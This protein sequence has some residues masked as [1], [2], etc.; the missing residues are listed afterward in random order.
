MRAASGDL[1]STI[2]VEFGDELEALA[3]NFNYMMAQIKQ[4]QEEL[5]RSEKLAAVG[6]VVNT[7][8]HDC[9][10]LITVIKGFASVL[11]EFDNSPAQQ[12]ECLDFIQFEVDRM[13]RMLDEILQF[14]VDLKTSLVFHEEPLDDFI[15]E[16]YTEIEVLLKT[17]QIQ[18]SSYQSSNALVRID[19]DKLRRTIL[20]L[21]ANALE[22]LKRAG[23]IRIK[24]ES[25]GRQAEVH[26]E[27][28][29]SGIPED[30]RAVLYSR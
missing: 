12:R 14:A 1:S 10:T 24:T 22:A 19:L 18:L 21:V 3:H 20:N 4:Q 13:D 30:L 28:T 16:C 25:V 11:Q 27:D 9:R 8:M 2:H 26:A 15:K 6:Y 7:V 23:E 5:I 17:T 29:G